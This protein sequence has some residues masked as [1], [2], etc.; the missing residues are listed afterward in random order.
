M[1]SRA[2]SHRR[3]RLCLAQ[4]VAQI[5]TRRR[6]QFLGSSQGS[7]KEPAA[8]QSQ[9]HRSRPLVAIE[10]RR[11]LSG[12]MLFDLGTWRQA[13]ATVAR[14]V[15]KFRWPRILLQRERSLCGGRAL[16]APWSAC[17][18]SEASA[19]AWGAAAPADPFDCC[20]SQGAWR[21]GFTME[22]GLLSW[23]ASQVAA[24]RQQVWRSRTGFWRQQSFG[25]RSTQRL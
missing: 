2:F 20:R 17:F 4:R 11:R 25:T 13:V 10:G 14:S 16:R 5:Q 22:S 3:N 6:L 12:A 18:G 1:I 19:P 9:G 8:L 23:T 7:G 24:C 21:R 15:W